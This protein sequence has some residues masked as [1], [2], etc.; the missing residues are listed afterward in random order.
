MHLSL[1]GWYS[2]QQLRGRLLAV[3]LRVVADPAPQVIASL[4]HG[5]LGLPLKLL[6]GQSRVGSQVK[7][8]ALAATYDFIWQ[9]AADDFAESLDD[10]KNSA[11]TSRAQ[12]PGLDSRLLLA[13]VVEGNQVAAG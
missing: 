3:A 2:V 11:A 13:K 5:Q 4:L 6:V 1:G 9:I 7:D 8:I 10:L 12:V